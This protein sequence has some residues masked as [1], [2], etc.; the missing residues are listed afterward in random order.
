[1][2]ESERAAIAAALLQL[3]G[4]T[5][6]GML[7]QAL[8]S[9]GWKELL[10]SAPAVAVPSLFLAQGRAGS[11]SS[12]LHDALAMA[13]PLEDHD[14]TGSAVL[15]PRP[16]SA[17]TVEVGGGRLDG[18]LIGARSGPSS[19]IA[20]DGRV[21]ATKVLRFAPDQVNVEPVVGLDQRLSVLRVS[22]E[23]VG[24]EVLCEGERARAW[25][26]EAVAVG[27]RAVALELCGAMEAMLELAVA[28]AGERYQ[29][30]R[31]IGSFQAVRHR[32][33]ECRVA[34]SGAY[35][36]A[37]ASFEGEEVE[38]SAMTA[39]VVAGRAQRQVGTHC[40]Q[41]LAGMGFTAEHSFHRYL[42]RSTVMDRVFGSAVELA[43]I[44][45]RAIISRG[46]PFRMAEL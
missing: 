3:A 6:S 1:V 2:D 45:G 7:T 31:P 27:R 46:G 15:V 16:G 21:D 34:T 19:M 9:F 39:K 40:Q 8:D 18:L 29:F 41:V 4:N 13:A 38:L 11:W 32:L 5:D 44:L 26:V 24:G 23:T 43:P 30:G 28:H 36:A 20:F 42:V 35:A 25:W 17:T 33:A 10:R 12:A 22:G 37:L 14:L